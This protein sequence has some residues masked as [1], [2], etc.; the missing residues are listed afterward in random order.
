MLLTLKMI[1]TFLV[2]P[3]YLS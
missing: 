3:N 1:S 2:T